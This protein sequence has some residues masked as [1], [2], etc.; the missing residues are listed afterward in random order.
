VSVAKRVVVGLSGGVDSA[1]AAHLLQRQGYDVRAV[2]LQLFS[3]Q[4]AED[5]RQVADK[6]GIS[7]QI[8]D[9]RELFRRRVIDSFAETYRRGRTPNPCVVCNRAAKWETLLACADET[10]ADYVATGHYAKL[11]RH[12]VTG[13][14]CLERAGEKDQTYALHNL[15]Q[16]QL[17]RTLMP[18]GGY[19]KPDV[20]RIAADLG[21]SVADK[22]DS[23]DIC[24]IP[25]GDYGQFLASL[26]IDSPPGNF[27]DQKGRVLGRHRGLI[28]YTLGQRKGLGMG[29]GRRVFVREI[30]PEANEIVL[31][32][33]ASAAA[34]VW[35][36]DVNWM[37]L[38]GMT[39][40]TRLTGKLRYAQREASCFAETTAGRLRCLFDQPQRAVT[41]GQS[42]VF[43]DGPFLACG[44]R[45]AASA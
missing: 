10:G 40:P 32:E 33:E 45:I 8:V 44:G 29:F 7:H 9:A 3:G 26:G 27:V 20:R 21:L 18:I 2:T 22:P 6:L 12:P 41:P 42:A 14:Y 1:V 24:F 36:E 37:A 31:G 39:G 16:E 35:V 17:A 34:E 28:H 15:S 23:Q 13:R 43:Y 19:M 25:D 4:A 38:P 30:R 5:A 11:V